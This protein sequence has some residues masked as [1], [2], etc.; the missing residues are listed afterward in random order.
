MENEHV[1]DVSTTDGGSVLTEL[2]YD[3]KVNDTSS[4]RRSW[5]ILNDP[6]CP[7]RL[8]NAGVTTGFADGQ[9]I[10]SASGAALASVAIC[11]VEI[12]FIAYDVFG[13]HMKT[14]S[15]KDFSDTASNARL[16]LK[17]LG[18][19]NAWNNEVSELLTV[20]GFV[21]KVRTGEGAVWKYR[22][23]PISDKL[24]D[25]HLA[26]TVGDLSPKKESK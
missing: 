4:L 11:A 14:L 5:V 20:V 16:D 25:I 23:G 17:K 9:F 21:A 24:T 12:R 8:I 13:D 1:I 22:E 26:V 2:G 18:T 3:L 10:F 6:T 7:V 19:W 15:L